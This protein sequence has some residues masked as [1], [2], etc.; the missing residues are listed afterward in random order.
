[1]A[2]HSCL[3]RGTYQPVGRIHLK[4]FI[5]GLFG[6]LFGCTHKIVRVDS[7]RPSKKNKF[8]YVEPALSGFNLRNKRLTLFDEPS[9]IRLREIRMLPGRDEKHDHSLIK[10]GMK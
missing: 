10:V 4:T 1:L 3:G 5:G 7:D 8:R 6:V 2:A 9:Q